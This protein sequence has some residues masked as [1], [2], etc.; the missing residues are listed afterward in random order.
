VGHGQ[1]FAQC[2]CAVGEVA[3]L[4]GLLEL[5]FEAAD[6][7]VFTWYIKNF[8]PDVNL[9]VDHGQTLHLE[10]LRSGVWGPTSLFG[11]IVTYRG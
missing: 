1:R 4:R 10:S 8:G 5:V 9:F 7:A 6:P 3:Q 11:R 2:L